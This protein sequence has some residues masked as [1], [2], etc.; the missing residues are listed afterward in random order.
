MRIEP[1]KKTRKQE[2]DDIR[3]L[4]KDVKALMLELND[5]LLE[6]EEEDEE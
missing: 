5:R 3:E 6:I 2:D 4:L 1:K